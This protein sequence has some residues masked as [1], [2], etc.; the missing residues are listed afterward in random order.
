MQFPFPPGLPRVQ[1]FEGKTLHTARC[2]PTGAARAATPYTPS[3]LVYIS[4]LSACARAC[5]GVCVLCQC[6][7]S[8]GTCMSPRRSRRKHYQW[9][10]RVAGVKNTYR[11]ACCGVWRQ[12]HKTLQAVARLLVPK[13]HLPARSFL[14]GWHGTSLS[15]P[16][17]SPRSEG[18][19]AWN[20][21]VEEGKTY[22]F[23]DWPS[24]R[25][26]HIKISSQGPQF[27]INGRLRE[28]P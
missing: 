21:K 20:Q 4:M 24:C 5:V 8:R 16:P 17:G 22:S 19:H 11:H 28:Q 2:G 10:L 23:K 15:N 6:Q 27:T 25:S 3:S 26:A 14:A 12:T 18:S 13:C 7:N 9:L 1:K